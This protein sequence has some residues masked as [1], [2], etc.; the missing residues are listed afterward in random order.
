MDRGQV[1][2]ERIDW[3]ENG[4]IKSVESYKYGIVIFYEKWDKNGNL[5]D[6][7]T[8]PT[9]SDKKILERLELLDTSSKHRKKGES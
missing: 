2:G 7:K 8:E 6:K 9:D 1:L 3:Y 4:T 5:I